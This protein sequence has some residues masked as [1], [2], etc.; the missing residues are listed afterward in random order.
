M[1]KIKRNNK[2]DIIKGIGI[3]LV[4]FGHVINSNVNINGMNINNIL[5]I[6]HMPLFFLV[7]GYLTKYEKDCTFKEYLK[8]KSKAILIPYFIFS[9]LCFIYWFIIERRIRHQMDV[10]VIKVL[11]NIPLGFI[12]DKYLLPN[13]VL[14]FLPCL[15][16]SEI[17]FYMIRKIK[18]KYIQ[19]LIEIIIFI[20]GIILCNFKIILP[21]GIET[22]FVSLLFLSIGNIYGKFEEK[23]NSKKYIIIPV[24]LIFY[25]LA[26][27][28]NGGISMLGHKYGIPY[29][30]VLGAISG[31]GIIYLISSL[32]ENTKIVNKSLVFLGKNSLTIMLCHDPIKRIIVKVVS[33]IIKID[34]E[35]IRNTLTGSFII[36]ILII[37][38]M[39][40]MI[41]IINKY[42]PF[43]VGKKRI[44]KCI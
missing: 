30:F 42:L 5:Y 19:Y 14:W 31:T 16:I 21:F 32:L 43:I 34:D 44:S 29:L 41:I 39:I 23:I 36:T 15:F 8:K 27:V 9:I 6:F 18:N 35:L 11:L 22:A 33:V 17:L 7:S 10:S 28:Y 4:V 12:N 2:I 20:V 13:I 40:Q 24:I 25:I 1:A 26:Y 37:L 3:I 38:V